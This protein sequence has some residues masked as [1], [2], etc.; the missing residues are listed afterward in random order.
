MS[1]R[2]RSYTH[3][4]KDADSC[5][6]LLEASPEVAPAE[7]RAA[8]ARLDAWLASAE[9]LAGLPACVGPREDGPEHA[10]GGVFGGDN[11]VYGELSLIALANA[12]SESR[13]RC[14]GT[15][16]L[17]VGSGFG[18]SLLLAAC[19]P[20][21]TVAR[22]VELCATRH[23][24][25]SRLASAFQAE[26]LPSLSPR[27]RLQLSCGDAE[28]AEM[29]L[30]E[31]S[32]VLFNCLMWESES[33]GRLARK[34]AAGLPPGAVV[35][36]VI[37][38]LSAHAPGLRLLR[39]THVR[40]SWGSD[41]LLLHTVMPHGGAWQRRRAAAGGGAPIEALLH[42]A[43]QLEAAGLLEPLLRGPNLLLLSVGDEPL[44]AELASAGRAK[45]HATD[46]DPICVSAQRA[47]CAAAAFCVADLQ[48]LPLDACSWGGP[49]AAEVDPGL[50]RFDALLDQSCL[51]TLPGLEEGRALAHAALCGIAACLRPGGVAVFLAQ[52]PPETALPL[53][54]AHPG[55]R[56]RLAGAR[57]LPSEACGPLAP[58]FAYTCQRELEALGPEA[59][60]ARVCTLA[61]TGKTPTLQQWAECAS[62]GLEAVCA[63][64]AAPGGCHD[65]HAMHWVGGGAQLGFCDCGFGVR[66]RRATSQDE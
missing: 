26:L 63:A 7:L 37:L 58:V 38:P 14:Q 51:D 5:E 47:R 29:G 36:T 41:D 25:A 19:C 57:Q 35:A 46:L 40:V 56:W 28:E 15:A 16:F 62:C 64:C 54:S 44:A 30:A 22:G 42:S 11:F 32:F 18:R 17:D 49:R 8:L 21:F 55:Y 50:L 61:A 13:D 65:G 10:V 39:T 43:A 52:A 45:V 27:F 12:M 66:C 48:D 60:G 3:F 31:T 9:P 20:W 2:G 34:L 6:A 33:V 23:E 4:G 59:A 1:C 24:A 53:L